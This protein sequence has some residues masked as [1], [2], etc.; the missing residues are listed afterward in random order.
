M[1]K[2]VSTG[3]TAGK[4]INRSKVVGTSAPEEHR[5]LAQTVSPVKVVRNMYNLS[6][7]G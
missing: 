7:W 2:T 6:D 4:T 5:R 3:G 1:A